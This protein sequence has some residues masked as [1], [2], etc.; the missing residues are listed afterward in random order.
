MLYLNINLIKWSLGMDPRGFAP[1][2]AASRLSL[3]IDSDQ[4]ELSTELYS[5]NLL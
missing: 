3:P 4:W 5:I 1:R 2:D